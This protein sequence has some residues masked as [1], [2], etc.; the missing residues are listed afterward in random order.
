MLHK[1]GNITHTKQPIISIV[2]PIYKAKDYLNQTLNSIIKQEV[3]VEVIAV[4]DPSDQLCTSIIESFQDRLLI[5]HIMN[6]ERRG[7]AENR[8]IGI[9]LARGRYIAFLDA[10][11]WWNVGKLKSQLRQIEQT[12]SPFVYTGRRLVSHDGRNKGKVIHVP[13]HITYKELLKGNIIPA[14]SVLIQSEIAKLHE[15]HH[16]HLHEDYIMWLEIL[17]EYGTA[18]GINT[19]FL[20][21]RLSEGGK[22]RNK[23]KSAKMHWGVLRLMGLNVIACVYY[24]VHYAVRGVMKYS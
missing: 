17:K 14:S 21:S 4:E 19:P 12:G 7:P 18:Y 11:D 9:R 1:E 13:H 16:D 15:Q 10:D 24:F 23:F 22:S 5:H 6:E 3:E 2:I 20:M 8:N